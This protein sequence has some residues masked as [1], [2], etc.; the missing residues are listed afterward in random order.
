MVTSI[1]TNKFLAKQVLMVLNSIVF[2]VSYF[3]W[4]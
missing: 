4:Y 1:N 2:T 3:S